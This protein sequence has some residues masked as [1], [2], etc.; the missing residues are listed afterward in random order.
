MK[1]ISYIF[2]LTIGLLI[3]NMSFA[4]PPS[5]CSSTW[6]N[7]SA[8]QSCGPTYCRGGGDV[9]MNYNWETNQCTFT[10][11]CCQM[12]APCPGNNEGDCANS[13]VTVKKGNSNINNCAGVLSI[14]S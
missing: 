14:Y 10:A 13:P 5:P 7:S 12:G 3:S 4:T 1:K 9:I 6:A 8:A 11:N 2:F